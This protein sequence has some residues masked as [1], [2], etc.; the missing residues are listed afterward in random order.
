MS[1]EAFAKNLVCGELLFQPQN[2]FFLFCV[3][4]CKVDYM[5]DTSHSRSG[6]TPWTICSVGI[7]VLLL[8]AFDSNVSPLFGTVIFAIRFTEGH[9]QMPLKWPLC[10]AYM[11]EQP[12]SW[13]I[14]VSVSARATLWHLLKIDNTCADTNVMLFVVL[15]SNNCCCSR[16]H[17]FSLVLRALSETL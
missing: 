3:K 17:L 13:E 9:Y 15:C 12:D 10:L 16:E 4:I 6:G 11:T 5:C 2:I 1:Q 7:G 8:R 14:S